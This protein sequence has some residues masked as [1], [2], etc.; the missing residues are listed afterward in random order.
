MSQENVEIVRRVYDAA[1]RR[2]TATVLALYDPEL[3]W[4]MTRRVG[5]GLWG[6]GGLYRG[7]EGLRRWF[8]EWS[9]GLD[10]IEYEAEEL[11]AAGD[12]RVISEAYMR[13]RG[14]AS[15][16]EVGA[17]LYAVWTIRE[18]KVVRVVWFSRREEALE[19][20]GLSE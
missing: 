8:R 13:G 19:A 15:G 20:A 3:E 12:D 18:G 4:D 11:I 17:T 14:R 16:I 6:Q 2:D 5:E 10:H 7:H 1:A 9:E